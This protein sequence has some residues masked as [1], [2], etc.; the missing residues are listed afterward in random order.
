MPRCCTFRNYLYLFSN[1][2]CNYIYYIA[3]ILSSTLSYMLRSRTSKCQVLLSLFFLPLPLSSQQNIVIYIFCTVENLIG[4]ENKGF[5][6]IMY[7]FNHERWLVIVEV[8]CSQASIFLQ[9]N[10]SPPSSLPFFP[11]SPPFFLL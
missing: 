6:Y 4:S 5:K 3:S 11:L 10:F 2:L 8:W 9:I 1:S 7:N